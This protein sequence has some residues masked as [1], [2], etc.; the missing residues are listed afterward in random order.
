MT[1][2]RLLPSGSGFTANDENEWTTV[3]RPHRGWWDLRLGELWDARELV[4]IFVWRDFVSVYKQ[5]ILGPLWHIIQPLL[6]TLVFT[7]I[8]GN[9]ARLPTDGL[10]PFLFYLCGTVIWGYFARCVTSTS[11]T[12]TSNAGLF[13]KVY[14]PRLAVPVAILLSNLISFAIQFVT[15]LGF[16]LF[17]WFVGADAKPNGSVV[18]IPLLL[19]LMA[20][21]GLALGLIVSSLTTR[22]RDLQQLVGFGVQLLMYATP[23]LYPISFVP[24]RY[25]LLIQANPLTPVIEAFRYAF[26][27][28]GSVSNGG[29]LYSLGAM[30]AL[31]LVGLL[32]FNRTEQTFMDSV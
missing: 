25:R 3:I 9:V 12:F 14:F 8:F 21:F 16:L 26:L 5:T 29:L 15:F 18:L 30:A 19:F 6:T 28:A 20:G 10:P 23:V 1:A 17:F 27:G 32:L 22:Y 4:G 31:L 13:G 24:E 2:E 7:V 11:T